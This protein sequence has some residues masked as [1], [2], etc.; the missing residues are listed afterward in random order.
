M[1]DEGTKSIFGMLYFQT[2]GVTN[3]H[4][5]K[6]AA[7]CNIVTV[8]LY[9]YFVGITTAEYSRE[10]ASQKPNALLLASTTYVR[11]C[12]A[13]IRKRL[14]GHKNTVVW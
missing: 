12:T 9:V 6:S 5:Y 3:T 4:L 8:R 10:C 14:F 2:G 1:I 11:M 13:D 7:F